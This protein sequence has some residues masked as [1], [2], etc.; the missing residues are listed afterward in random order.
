MIHTKR[1][2]IRDRGTLIP[3]IA[4]LVSGTNDPL[5]RRAGFGD[6]PLVMLVHLEGEKVTWDPFH[7]PASSR[8]MREAHLWLRANWDR[9]R[10]GGVVDVEYILC[11]TS[12]PK[13]SEVSS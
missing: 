5:L 7:W 11:E 9:H 12:A 3:A 4:L 10:D 1:V 13:E 2:E 8:T 6:E